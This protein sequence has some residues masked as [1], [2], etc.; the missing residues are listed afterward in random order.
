MSKATID[1]GAFDNDATAEKIRLGFEKVNDNFTEVYT[2]VPQVDPSTLSGQTG[3]FLKV[4]A[5]ETAFE[6]AA[7]AGGGDLLAS[8]NLSDVASAST[9]RTNLG[10]G[11]SAVA[12][13]I[14]EDTF[15]TDSA[16]QVP[17]QQSVKAYV[18]A[19][20][21][22]YVAGVG[23]SIQTTSPYTAAAPGIVNTSAANNVTGVTFAAGT[24]ILTISLTTGTVTVD[25]TAYTVL[26]IDG[27]Q[28]DKG[29]GNTN[30]TT[31]EVGDYCT[32][33]ETD[34]YVAFKVT[35]LPYLTSG[36]RSFAIKNSI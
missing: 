11:S 26:K 2:T 6:L 17:S 36:N 15:A 35:A 24:R 34:E 31:I 3:K 10:L 13:L 16:T 23:I 4:N 1:N 5:G 14:D 30:Y 25:L 9:S 19:Q 21:L 7:V 29:S 20:V 28:V 27:Y 22:D 12:D 8:N 18:D 32:G 33:W